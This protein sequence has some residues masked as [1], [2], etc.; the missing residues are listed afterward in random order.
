[1]SHCAV[2]RAW[3]EPSMWGCHGDDNDDDNDDDDDDDD[4]T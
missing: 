2:P 1:M 3:Q 4:A